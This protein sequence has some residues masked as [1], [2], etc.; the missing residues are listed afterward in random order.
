MQVLT[1]FFYKI[2]YVA[3]CLSFTFSVIKVILDADRA[4]SAFGYLVIN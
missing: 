3:V 1:G 4:I 2:M